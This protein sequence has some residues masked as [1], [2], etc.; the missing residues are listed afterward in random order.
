MIQSNS[1]FY[2]YFFGFLLSPILLSALPAFT[3]ELYSPLA[4][5][6]YPDNVYWGDT[7]LHSNLSVD[8]YLHGNRALGPEAAYRFAKGEVI[9]TNSGKRVQLRRPLD[10]LIVADHAFN[11]G[12][13]KGIEQSNADLLATEEGQRWQRARRCTRVSPRG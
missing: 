4:D 3:G 7:H 2:R 5:Q 9:K 12:V 13:M 11:M 6:S 1:D 8:A 10:F